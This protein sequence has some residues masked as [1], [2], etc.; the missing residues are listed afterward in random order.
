MKAIIGGLLIGIIGFFFPQIFGVG[1]ETVD[2]V[3]HQSSSFTIIFSLIFIK[4][5]AMSITL[6]EGGSGGVLA[7]SLFTGGHA[8]W[9]LKEEFSFSREMK[10]FTTFLS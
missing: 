2:V 4:I 3:L 6:G 5:I 7:S 10:D 1:Y 8:R 9:S